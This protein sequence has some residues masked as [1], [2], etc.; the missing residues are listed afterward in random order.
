MEDVL[1]IYGNDGETIEEEI[2]HIVEDPEDPWAP[3]D[4]EPFWCDLWRLQDQLNAIGTDPAFFLK[5]AKEGM[6][7][8]L[9]KTIRDIDQGLEQA[10]RDILKDVQ[11]E[12]N[13]YNTDSTYDDSW[14]DAAGATPDYGWEYGAQN[15]M[16][17]EG[18][19]E[20][21][22]AAAVAEMI[23]TYEAAMEGGGLNLAAD[24]LE[25]PSWE[26]DF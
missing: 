21:E 26:F 17:G 4:D 8:E 18:M 1:D 6:K 2:M 15:L 22:E 19:T 14:T 10:K 24:I 12:H 16:M 5:H 7:E 11:E 13:A 20:D 9:A 25:P 3:C 23:H